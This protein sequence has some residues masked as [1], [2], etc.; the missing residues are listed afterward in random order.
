M[1]WHV[2]TPAKP[3]LR[4]ASPYTKLIAIIA[5]V[6][7]VIIT[8]TLIGIVVIMIVIIEM[9]AIVIIFRIVIIVTDLTFSN[10]LPG[11]SYYPY[12]GIVIGLLISGH[13]SH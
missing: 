12:L 1:I 7:V 8:I 13:L 11:P 6:V 10:S 4:C 3:F 9:I 2:R 5:L